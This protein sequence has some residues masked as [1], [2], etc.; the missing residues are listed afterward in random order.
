MYH[1][2]CADPTARQLFTEWLDATH[3]AWPGRFSIV[4]ETGETDPFGPDDRDAVVQPAV[5]V[6][7]GPPHGTVRVEWQ[8]APATAEIHAERPEARIWM[9]PEA[10]REF[11]ASRR[12]F[13]LVVLIFL[14]K[15]LG[16]YHTHGAS[17][18]DPR[19]RGW[20]MIGNSHCGKS[21]TS[22]IVSRM[23]WPLTT[24]DIGFLAQ[25]GDRAAVIGVRSALHLRPGGR[26]MMGVTGGRPLRKTNRMA[27]TPEELGGRWI[28]EVVP[29]IL[30]FPTLGDRTAAVPASR[31]RAMA[32]VVEWSRWVLY[33][34][35]GAQAHLDVLVQ[36]ARQSQCYDL[37]LGPDLFERPQLLEELIP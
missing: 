32:Q 37:T 35:L 12:N 36:I 17:F 13:N 30:L 4:V 27:Y 16:W 14:L 2:E 26:E 9:S 11:D 8:H 19:G 10:I 1:L 21:T 5:L 15:R 28:P 23:G 24:D 29:E 25:R 33:E 18:V 3:L 7:S 6:R 31:R 34:P 20:L 22:A